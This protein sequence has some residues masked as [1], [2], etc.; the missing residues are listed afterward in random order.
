[1][2]PLYKSQINLSDL[3][4]YPIYYILLI[5][6]PTWAIIEC[7]DIIKYIVVGTIPIFCYV[8]WCIFINVYYFY[9]DKIKIVYI[10]RFIRRER[11]VFYSDIKEIRYIHT[12]GAKQPMVAF[13]YHGKTFS[14]ILWP[15]NSFT[16]RYFSKRIEILLFL[17][18]RGIPIIVNSVFKRDKE[19]FK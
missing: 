16:H 1:M 9:E 11:S 8:I 3:I 14:K 10:F 18:T 12:A 6:Y 17:N 2:N 15:S 19:I 13:I 4:E 7:S 5:V